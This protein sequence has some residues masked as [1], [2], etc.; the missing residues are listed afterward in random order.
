MKL[1]FQRARTHWNRGF[2]SSRDRLG[3]EELVFW[4]RPPGL[5][6]EAATASL[7]LIARHVLPALAG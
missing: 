4:A 2:T 5:P 7:E 3:Y 1:G 6:V